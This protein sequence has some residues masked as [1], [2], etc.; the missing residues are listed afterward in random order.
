MFLSERNRGFISP[1]IESH[2][3]DFY[4]ISKLPT[5]FYAVQLQFEKRW[6]LFR[7]R[8]FRP[9][10]GISIPTVFLHEKNLNITKS[11]RTTGKPQSNELFNRNMISGGLGLVAGFRYQYKRWIGLTSVS[12]SYYLPIYNQKVSK[13]STIRPY[14]EFNAFSTLQIGY[15][16]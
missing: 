16:F 7:R 10:G 5:S 8:Q 14:H 9:F 1:N 15:A 11:D 12:I 3:K 4:Y 6:F 13:E 2:N